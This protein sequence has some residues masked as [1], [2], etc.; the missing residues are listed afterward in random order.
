M[1]YLASFMKQ[2]NFI[3]RQYIKKKLQLKPYKGKSLK[4]YVF[5]LD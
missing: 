3:E 2:N 1:S 5:L 4:Q